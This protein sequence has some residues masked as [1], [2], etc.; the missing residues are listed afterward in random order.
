MKCKIQQFFR[1]HTHS[2]AM[3]VGNDVINNRDNFITK[4]KLSDDTMAV[5]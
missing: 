5:E 4:Q 1:K 3:E 2:M